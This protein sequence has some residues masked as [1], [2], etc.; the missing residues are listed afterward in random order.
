MD[1][2]GARDC[3]VI[4]LTDDPEAEIRHYVNDIDDPTPVLVTIKPVFSRKMDHAVVVLGVDI[5]ESGAEAVTFMDPL[6]GNIAA[7]D[8]RLFFQQWDNAG[9]LAFVI[10]A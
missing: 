10:R 3:D 1:G 4:E 9:Q 2:L 8:A 5:K 6:S 7:L